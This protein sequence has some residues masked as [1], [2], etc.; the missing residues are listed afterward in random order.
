MNTFS[1]A[2]VKFTASI[3]NAIYT[4][5]RDSMM[6]F[7]LRYNVLAHITRTPEVTKPDDIATRFFLVARLINSRCEGVCIE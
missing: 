3:T 1:Q 2:S 4:H 5:L 7:P 6:A